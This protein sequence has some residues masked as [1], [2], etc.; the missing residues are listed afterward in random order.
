VLL[1]SPGDFAR[2]R[3]ALM[4][5]PQLNVKVERLSDYYHGQMG[6]LLTLFDFVGYFVGGI[7]AIGATCG[8]L[9]TLFAAVD[10]R[11]REIATLRAIGFGGGAIVASVVIE[12]LALAL[13][14]ALIGLAITGLAFNGHS[15]ATGGVL[16]KSTVTLS[17]AL[18]GA[19]AAIAIGLIG[20]L[21]PAVRAASSPIAEAL[22]AT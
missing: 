15:I 3:D 1:R 14:G 22:R 6:Q 13:P 8:A 18:I 5:N 21:F 16:F 12:A 17:L 19:T 10:A 11:S 2:F 9:T 7:M 4:T 20:G